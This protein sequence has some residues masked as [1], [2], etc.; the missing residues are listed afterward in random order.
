VDS[1]VKRLPCFA[2]GPDLKLCLS[3]GVAYQRDMTH[4]VAYDESYFDKCAGYED[5]DIAVLI[6]QRRIE[7][8]RRHFGDGIVL[9]VGIGSGE[10]IKK[11]LDTFGFDINPKAVE[12]LKQR[13]QF[14]NNFYDF[15]AFTFWDVIEHLEDPAREYFDKIAD[16]SYLFTALPIFM[17]LGA[18][19]RSKHY[20]PGEHLYYW[21]H[22]GFINFMAHHRFRMIEANDLE[23]WAGRESIT[24]FAFIKEAD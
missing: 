23:T 5:K 6:N 20:R 2:D 12:W 11:R 3:F 15:Y 19:R 18:I 13:G 9:D 17:D 22:A 4:R 14:R 8:V 7:L 24:S 10:F 21:T 16:G 1:F